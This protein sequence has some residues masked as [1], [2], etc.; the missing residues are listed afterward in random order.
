MSTTANNRT[1]ARLEQQRFAAG[2]KRS[3]DQMIRIIEGKEER[4][5]NLCD[6]IDELREGT[7]GEEPGE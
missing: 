5:Q 6:F 2:F 4:G 7:E 3:F 1:A